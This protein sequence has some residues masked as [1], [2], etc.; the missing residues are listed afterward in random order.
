MPTAKRNTVADPDYP[1]R[2]ITEK[3][4]GRVVQ[5]VSLRGERGGWISQLL[6]D[7]TRRAVA[8]TRAASEKALVAQLLAEDEDDMAVI[9]E[10]EKGKFLSL[11]ELKK[12]HG[13]G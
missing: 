1:L 6:S 10:R 2:D 11:D 7:S 12:R 5:L 8:K 4:S 9:R 3:R 13:W